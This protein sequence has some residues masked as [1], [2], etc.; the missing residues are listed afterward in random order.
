MPSLTR[1]TVISASRRRASSADCP[2]QALIRLSW[3]SQR[4][5]LGGVLKRGVCKSGVT[6]RF[7]GGGAVF[8]GCRAGGTGE[9]ADA[10]AGVLQ[11]LA[12]VFFGDP[13]VARGGG[14]GGFGEDCLVQGLTGL[15]VAPEQR[16]AVG[17]GKAEFDH[18]GREAV[19]LHLPDP[20]GAEGG[21][22]AVECKVLVLPLAHEVDIFNAGFSILFEAFS[23]EFEE[24][25][26]LLDQKD[27]DQCEQEE[28][29]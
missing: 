29:E 9:V 23:V 18:C 11:G 16:P 21:E 15:A 17:P 12:E 3:P 26:A 2:K 4:K 24:A 28:S 22:H 6:V 7:S 19:L 1:K 25:G 13:A 14:K 5:Y 10:P 8:G 20:F 27:C